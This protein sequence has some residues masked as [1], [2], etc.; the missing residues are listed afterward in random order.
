MPPF[1][2]HL[3]ASPWALIVFFLIASL[4]MLNSLDRM[5]NRG[6]EGTVVGTL[7]MPYCSGAPNL[8]FAGVLAFRNGP[9]TEVMVNAIVNNVTNLSLLIGLP[10]LVWA[11]GI[12]PRRKLSRKALKEHRLG[13][14][15]LALTLLAVLFFTGVT[16]GLGR[17]G[18]LTR[19]DGLALVGMF[20]FWQSFQVFDV[21]RTNIERQ[22]RLSLLFLL[23]AAQLAVGGVL[24]FVSIDRLVLWLEGIQ[25]GFISY[26]YI[27][28]LS[29]W[30]MVLPNAVPAFYYA[31]K[32]RADVVYSSQVGDGHICIPLCI[33]LFALINP[34]GIPPF[35]TMAM[36]VLAGL[37]VFH[38]LFVAVL[39]RLPRP[40]AA[41]L[42]LA[43]AAFVY[44]GI[45][46]T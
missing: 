4:L 9:G 37:S 5:Q 6:L 13:K 39:G 8:I 44:S 38:L 20:L 34:V 15:S 3:L 7:I 40:A 31:A 30:L 28:W 18:D 32:Q 12:M 27:G 17:D 1:F 46:A 23:D 33:G 42:I 10:G 24:M 2:S 45:T 36:A 11:L 21:L 25:T 22:R 29:G 16:W 26:R 19:G 43:Y 14:L 35:F 41:A